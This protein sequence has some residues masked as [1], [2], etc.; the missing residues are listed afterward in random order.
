MGCCGAS[1]RTVLAA[2]AGV[3]LAAAVPVS[4]AAQFDPLIALDLEIVTVTER[5]VVLTWTTFGLD[6]A[7]RPVPTATDTEV[8]LAPADS[9]R[10][11]VTVYHDDTRTPYHYA[12]IDDLE[13]G[14]PYRFLALSNGIRA[15]L[16]RR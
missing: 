5:G 8:R 2:A 11:P 15:Y 10:E 16:P 13:P 14:R 1:R 6:S 12:E 3:A 7:G 4:G 9:P